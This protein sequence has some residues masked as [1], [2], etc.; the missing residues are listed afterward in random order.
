[1]RAKGANIKLG[2]IFPCILFDEKTVFLKILWQS[3]LLKDQNWEQGH[4]LLWSQGL[5]YLWG[6][7]LG[8]RGCLVYHR[9]V[10][11]TSREADMGV[12]TVWYNTNKSV[13]QLK[14]PD[15]G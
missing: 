2:R 11:P 15:L 12:K 13:L 14:G 1:M 6:T 9:Q 4:I 10:S 5:S 8:G 3:Y 7:S